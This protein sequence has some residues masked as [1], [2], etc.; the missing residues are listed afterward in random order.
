VQDFIPA[1][2]DIAACMYHTGLDP[3]T[4]Q[5]VH[6]AKGLR[7]RKIQ[8]AMMQFFKPE[9]YFTVRRALV[10][11]GRADLIGDGCDCLI[12]VFPLQAA[13]DARRNRA[14]LEAKSDDYVHSRRRMP[15]VGYRPGRKTARK[16]PRMPGSA[17]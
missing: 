16:R 11:A 14:A 7:D 4:M 6:V 1:P 10:E 17:E 5:P 9:N 3:M 15:M 8:R 2:F 13:I 12:P